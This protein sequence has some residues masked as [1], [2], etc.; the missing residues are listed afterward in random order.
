MSFLGISLWQT[1]RVLVINSHVQICLG[2]DCGGLG[3][4]Q[5]VVLTAGE[6]KRSAH[7]PDTLHK[8][9]QVEHPF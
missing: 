8:T 7:L 3:K 6:Y 9:L 1:H 2:E 5:E 4:P